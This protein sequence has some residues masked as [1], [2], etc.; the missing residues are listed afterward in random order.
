[1]LLEGGHDTAYFCHLASGA[2]IAGAGGVMIGASIF[3]SL[4]FSFFFV[5]FFSSVEKVE[6]VRA[7]IG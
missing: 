5:L 3:L 4:F 2:M 7:L 6:T 1:M